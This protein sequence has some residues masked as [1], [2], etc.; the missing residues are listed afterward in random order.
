M[1][2]EAH[3]RRLHIHVSGLVQGVG[4]R[5]YAQY[6]GQ[7]L[8]LKGW[9]RNLRDGRVEL[10]AEGPEE[11]LEKLAAWCRRGPPAAQVDEVDVRWLEATGEFPDFSI[12]R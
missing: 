4:Y 5:A 1:T 2:T 6:K 7:S 12:R 9:V 3:L 10:V 11:A 8:G